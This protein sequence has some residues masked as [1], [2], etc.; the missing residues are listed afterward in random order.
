VN[1]QPTYSIIFFACILLVILFSACRR[2]EPTTWDVNGR[3]PLVKG[4]LGWSDLITDSL[5][6]TDADGL[7]HLIYRQSL[8]NFDFDTLVAIKDTT[9]SN[10]FEPPFSGG[11]FNI[12]P[13]TEIFASDQN[14]NLKAG[15]AQIRLARIRSGKLI[16][17]LRSYIS[18]QLEVNYDLPGAILPTGS[19]LSLNIETQTAPEGGFWE[20]TSTVDLAGVTLDLQGVSGTSFNRLAST[21]Q[22]SASSNALAAV[23]IMG[24]DQ[25]SIDLRFEALEVAYGKGYFGQVTSVLD[26]RVDTQSLIG[27]FGELT[28]DALRLD[29][30]FQNRIGA[31]LRVDLDA[32]RA[33]HPNG[34]VDLLHNLVY[35]PVNVTRAIDNNG[36]VSGESYN[37]VIDETNS[38]ILSLFSQIPQSFEFQGELMLNPLGN[39]SGSNDFIY[40]D[41]PFDITW[42][43]DIPMCFGSGGLNLRDTLT[44]DAF[45]GDLQADAR[46]LVAFSNG[47]PL[48]VNA[49]NLSFID[50]NGS[51]F[52]VASGLQIL[53]GVYAG[54]D[55]VSSANSEFEIALSRDQLL[56]IQAGGELVFEVTFATYAGQQV[57][58]TG[59]E[60][61]GINVRID[62]VV[63]MSY[64]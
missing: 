63:Q 27:L 43:L 25:V 1:R 31:D 29:L 56:R 9:F 21:I 35:Q 12:P 18:G 46:L 49:M 59:N 3:I 16:Y 22:V 8:T 11:P 32:V 64:E 60:E 7:L 45:A 54:F 48:A 13:G 47:F 50:E 28:L 33:I 42:G 17:T 57:K 55:Q 52:N 26:E 4:S 30:N 23:P 36:S 61:L 6:Q 2:D 37:F 51:A 19:N 53:S 38:N 24:D 58:F 40:T 44:I 5:L 14:I 15:G 62:G 39:I 20:Y 41:Q 34:S 10:V